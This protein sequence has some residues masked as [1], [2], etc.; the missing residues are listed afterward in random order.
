[1]NDSFMTSDAMKGSFTTS[2]RPTHGGPVAL[3]RGFLNGGVAGAALS[4]FVRV[5]VT[6]PGGSASVVLPFR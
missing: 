4:A 3:A 2:P 5:T 1:M 6:G